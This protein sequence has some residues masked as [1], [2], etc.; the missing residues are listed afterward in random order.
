MINYLTYLI[1]ALVTIVIFSFC[2]NYPP[3]TES[4]NIDQNKI[5]QWTNYL[6][7]LGVHSHKQRTI[8][9]FSRSAD[10]RKYENEIKW[11]DST[12]SNLHDTD[13]SF[14]FKRPKP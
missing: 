7:D 9:L 14:L 10:C 6:E 1:F 13:G 4:F 12:V 5:D 3:G 8:I 2:E 11:W